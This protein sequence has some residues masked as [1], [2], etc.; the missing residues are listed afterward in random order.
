VRSVELTDERFYHLDLAFCPVDER[1]AMVAPQALDRYGCRV[2]ES[3]VPEPIWLED[4]EASAFCA[5]SIV[6]GSSVIMS[7]CTPRL[8]QA[9]K[10]AGYEAVVVPVGEF[11]KAGGGCRCLTL[12]LDVTLH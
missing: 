4:D 7:A 5:N 11:L 1:F 3:L 8:A 9:L 2:I 12:S 10:K 6:I